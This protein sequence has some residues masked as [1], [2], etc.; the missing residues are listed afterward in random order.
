M[1]DQPLLHAGQLPVLDP[2]GSAAV[3]FGSRGTTA[4]DVVLLEFP[5]AQL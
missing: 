2:P 1:L 4:H 3:A 5:T